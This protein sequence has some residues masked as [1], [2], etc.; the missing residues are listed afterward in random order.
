MQQ[1]GMRPYFLQLT[2]RGPF[3]TAEEQAAWLALRGQDLAPFKSLQIYDPEI[4]G[5]LD[6]ADAFAAD[7]KLVL[8]IVKP[9]PSRTAVFAFSTGVADYLGTTPPEPLVLCAQLEPRAK[10][11]ARG[12]VVAPWD[13]DQAFV[14]PAAPV[15]V[16]PRKYVR[17]YA[18]TREVA[19]DLSPWIQTKA[20][21]VTSL[22]HKAWTAVAAR[23]LLG[24]LVST[25]AEDD[26]VFWLQVSGPPIVR[27]RADDANL[28]KACKELRQ[29]S[30]SS[31]PV[32]TLK[33]A[34]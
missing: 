30:G 16:Q 15:P 21:A 7:R 12:L 32:R 20:P 33:S 8:T 10:I 3:A 27:V 6:H 2:L 4:G 5:D 14:E 22:E 17:D 29:P 13:W 34:T 23:R 26:G 31:W 18:P 11:E 19:D 1:P 28:S 9:K 25:A 24:G